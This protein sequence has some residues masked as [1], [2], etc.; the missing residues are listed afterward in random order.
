MRSH[1]QVVVRHVVGHHVAEGLVRRDVDAVA[2]GPRPLLLAVP[3]RPPVDL[4]GWGKRVKDE[5]LVFGTVL[6]LVGTGVGIEIQCWGWG[7]GQEAVCI[8][9]VVAPGP[10]PLLFGVSGRPPVDLRGEESRMRVLCSG[11]S[12]S[13]DRGGN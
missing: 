6:E 9:D 2:P 11:R 7:E 1:S 4:R 10:R 8:C 13:W 3:G 5:G 12:W